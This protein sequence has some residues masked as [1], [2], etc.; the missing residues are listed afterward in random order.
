MG[1][2]G[3]VV[4][5]RGEVDVCG[6][7]VCHVRYS[8]GGADDEEPTWSMATTRRNI[9]YIV[10]VRNE[11]NY[12]LSLVDAQNRSLFSACV[13]LREAQMRVVCMIVLV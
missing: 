2:V 13:Y 1:G 7:I 9:V 12:E 8:R 6:V 5:F 3:R 11:N 10:I 4:Y